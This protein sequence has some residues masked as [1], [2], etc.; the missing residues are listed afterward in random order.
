M[1]LH[2]KWLHYWWGFLLNTELWNDMDVILLRDDGCDRD[3]NGYNCHPRKLR[4]DVIL[5]CIG[6]PRRWLVDGRSSIFIL[7]ASGVF[8]A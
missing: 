4:I 8:G 2:G 1:L 5:S 7:F 3:L 6:H